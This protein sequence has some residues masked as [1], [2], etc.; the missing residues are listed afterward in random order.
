LNL[1]SEGRKKRTYLTTE[2][3][4]QREGRTETGRRQDG[5]Q[6]RKGC[7]RERV[8][9]CLTSLCFFFNDRLILTFLFFEK[10]NYFFVTKLKKK[11][12]IKITPITIINKNP[13]FRFI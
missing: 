7:E 12:N 1:K 11:K 5:R 10:I 13:H 3:R 8:R 4:R 2:K 9:L 6:G